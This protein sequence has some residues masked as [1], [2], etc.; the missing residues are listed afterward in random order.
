MF[1]TFLTVIAFLGAIAG[2][3]YL[4]TY[5]ETSKAICF[6]VPVVLSAVAGL[7][8]HGGKP[9]GKIIAKDDQ[10]NRL[11]SVF[12]GVFGIMLVALEIFT[13]IALSER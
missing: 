8:A 9:S 12:W 1:K 3:I 10:G 13:F 2:Q 4:C 5:T 6:L 7:A 11:V